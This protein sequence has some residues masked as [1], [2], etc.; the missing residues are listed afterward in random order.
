[1]YVCTKQSDKAS[2]RAV[3]REHERE[4][5]SAPGSAKAKGETGHT[6]EDCLKHFLQV[7]CLDVAPATKDMYERHSGHLTRLLGT[8]DVGKLTLE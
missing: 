6:V 7:G 4:A 8:F 3:L 1:V 2:A 5:H